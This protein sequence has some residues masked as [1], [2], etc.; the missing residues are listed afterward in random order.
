MT[1]TT[2][3]TFPAQVTNIV[4]GDTLDVRVDLGF[5]TQTIERVRIRGID[6][7]EVYGVDHDSAEYERGK[8]HSAAT[9][10]WVETA[11]EQYD[12]DWSFRLYS[13]EYERGA[14]GRV[15]GRIEAKHSRVNLAN[16]LTGEFDDLGE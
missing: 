15:I 12:G 11:R 9:R 13:E 14:Y 8:R 4:D 3:F 1:E 16:Y 2:E 6:T 7:A 10:E 5:E